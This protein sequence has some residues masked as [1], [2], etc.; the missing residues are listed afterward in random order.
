MGPTD[1]E[2]RVAGS[3]QSGFF[4]R[5]GSP[6]A[7]SGKEKVRVRIRMRSDAR[8]QNRIKLW[9]VIVLL[10][11]SVVGGLLLGVG[12]GRVVR[13]KLGSGGSGEAATASP[14]ADQSPAGKSADASETSSSGGR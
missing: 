2:K 14:S 13:N 8:T 9:W 10:L 12:A 6:G 3:S 4:E 5:R 11:A 1:R 7:D